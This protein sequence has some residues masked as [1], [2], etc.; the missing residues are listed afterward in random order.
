MS[1][2]TYQPA[3]SRIKQDERNTLIRDLGYPA[4]NEP[5][6]KGDID[7]LSKPIAQIAVEVKSGQLDPVDVLSTYTRK[8]LRAHVATNCLTEILAISAR[9]YAK[10]CN[11]EGPLAGVPV[12]LKDVGGV[13][14]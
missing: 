1:S 11:K 14:L 9:R 2:T 7:L 6:S 13:T 3:P 5:V 8:A 4:M 12:S 10:A